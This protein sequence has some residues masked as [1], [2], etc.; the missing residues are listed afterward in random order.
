[1]KDRLLDVI[2]FLKSRGATYGDARHVRV[3][4]ETIRVRDASPEAVVRDVTEGVGIRVIADGA[5]G[6]A[7]SSNLTPAALRR[8]A[9]RAL[10][11]ARASALVRRGEVRL[12]DVEPAT[13]TW[14]SPFRIDPLTVKLDRKL[15]L[16]LAVNDVLKR[17]T[18]IRVAESSMSF[19]RTRKVFASTEGSV[20]EQDILE[21]GAGCVATAVDGGEV[22]RRSYPN[23]FGGDFG[24]G[25]YEIVEE[26]RLGEHAETVREE[27]VELL[28][29]PPMPAG[30]FDVVIG[31]S[32]LALQ[33]HESC[34][35]PAELD[36]VLGTEISLAGG[37]F[38]TLD[39]AGSFRYGSD[40]VTITADATLPGALGTFG[41]DDEG[42]AA[43]RFPIVAAGTFVGYLGSRETA[44]AIGGRSN[45]AMRAEGWWAIPLIRMTNVSL[46]PGRGS[47]DDLLA[48]TDG[49]FLVDTNKSW[50]I[51]DHRLNFQFG[52]EIAW[53]IEGGKR[54]RI[55]KNPLYTGMTPAFWASCDAICG[56][57]AWHAWG[58]PNCGKGEPLQLARVAHGTAPARFR[59]LETGVSA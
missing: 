14:R 57:D 28:A 38:L 40:L 51:D 17:R 21:S 47:L 18:E 6:F 45:G 55:H 31:G 25:G 44:A 49:G 42:V 33:V 35:H 37:S 50:S 34:G 58:V 56:R 11:V 30:R 52:T 24:T 48:D 5:W 26:L 29:A 20:I 23:S 39:K 9:A 41:Y 10:Q 15:D 7:A 4:T 8:T 19:I 43:Q 2:A 3:D 22:Q 27:A 1:V 36:R 59:G 53:K 16:L 12:A 32:Q 13:A 54:G 46:E